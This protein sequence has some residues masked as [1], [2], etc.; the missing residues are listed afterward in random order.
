MHDIS[1]NNCH[2]YKNNMLETHS[3]IPRWV[4]FISSLV[5]GQGLASDQMDNASLGKRTN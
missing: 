1:E 5:C 2:D 4:S 3:K